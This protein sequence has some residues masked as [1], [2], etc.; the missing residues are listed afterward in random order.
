MLLIKLFKHNKV[1]V[2][3]VAVFTVFVMLKCTPG[4]G[5]YTVTSLLD[6]HTSDHTNHTHQWHWVQSE[7]PQTWNFKPEGAAKLFIQVLKWLFKLS[8]DDPNS[9]SKLYIS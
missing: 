5:Q 9:A 3:K 2:V 4:C 1:E 6:V 7:A 8:H